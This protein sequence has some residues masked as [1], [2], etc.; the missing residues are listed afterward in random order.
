MRSHLIGATAILLS[1][2]G[3][4]A[5]SPARHITPTVVMKKQ[6][7]VIRGSLPDATRFF[8]KTV[9]IGQ[10]DFRRL[11]DEAG[12]EPEE[13]EMSFY[14]GTASDGSVSGVVL[15]PQVN[16]Q[17]G[18][19]EIGLVLRPDGTIG[20]VQVTKATVETKPWM[21]TAI[22]TGFL[23]AF[24][25]MGP[26]SDPRTALGSVDKSMI[27]EMPYYMAGLVVENVTRGLVLYQTLYE[28][29]AE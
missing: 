6:A 3:L 2:G 5:A 1:L 11:A 23:D 7:D 24:V 28:G 12:F 16:T 8:Q 21:Q 27:G 22:D 26:M 9:T 25:G 17:H 29:N 10:A 20:G 13:S 18:P 14:Y 4:A 19:L 15:F